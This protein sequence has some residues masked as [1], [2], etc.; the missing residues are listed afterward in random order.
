MKKI[1]LAVLFACTATGAF[2]QKITT[3]AGNGTPGTSG[4]N[5]PATAALMHNPDGIAV[6]GN[7]LYIG[8]VYSHR[9]RKI[10]LSTGII[11]AFAGT[12]VSGYSGD[13]FA[14]TNAQ[15]SN[16]YG[17]S[18]DSSGNLYITDQANYVVRKVNT[19]GI[20][21]TFAGSGTYGFSGDNG[22]AT[23]ANI[24][25]VNGVTPD[26]HGNLFIAD[27]NNYCV[28]KVDATGII[29]TIAGTPSTAGSSGDGGP[30]SAC[31]FRTLTD[32][33][34]DASGILYVSDYGNYKVRTIDL[35]GN[36]N[37]IVGDG[38]SG[39]TGNGGPATA[40][41]C[42]GTTR[43]WVDAE[44]NI[45]FD[46]AYN[47]V[48]RKIDPSGIIT[49]EVGSGTVGYS[50]DGG[51]ATAAR[52]GAVGPITGDA[53]GHLFICDY[54]NHCIRK[55]SYP[56]RVITGPDTV[57]ITSSIT[58]ANFIG[59]GIWHSAD[60][61]KATIDSSTGIVTGISTGTVNISYTANDSTVTTSVYV[62]DCPTSVAGEA[63]RAKYPLAVFP[64]PSHGTFTINI[65]SATRDE[66][67]IV[68]TNM[69][70]EK[71]KEL[72][73]TTN[74]NTSI[75]LDVPAGIY[76]VAAITKNNTATA[77]ISIQ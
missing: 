58:L 40:A 64:D 62:K 68:I 1:L 42:S 54:G 28:R 39:Y 76:F 43:V 72:E 63:A 45:F 71:V 4:D 6:F 74:M 18:V 35:A 48:V 16:V 70:G 47:Y 7:N 44:G 53:C 38:F 50:G 21:T 27:H 5:G 57:C 30:A 22:P 69:M 2:A 52:L 59:C 14:A 10:D 37:T 15:L 65:G 66:A 49:V 56:P 73:T 26:L 55:V 67:I 75:Q 32:V 17:I 46:D 34:I 25:D 11:T 29:T 20:I 60:V 31:T 61:S 77:K 13:G 3:I 23:A 24:S 36:V 33:S 12:G 8:E 41:E 9:V 19:A 51:P